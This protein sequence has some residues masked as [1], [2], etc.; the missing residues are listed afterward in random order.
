MTKNQSI[1]KILLTHI[2]VYFYLHQHLKFILTVSPTTNNNN[3]NNN[4][5]N[6]D[7]KNSS[8]L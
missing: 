7:I 4:D 5:N 8:L 6:N 2:R 3:N 1:Q